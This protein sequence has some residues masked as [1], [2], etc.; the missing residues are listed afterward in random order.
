[1]KTFTIALCSCFVLLLSFSC[2]NEEKISP[3]KGYATFLIYQKV[4]PGGR[5]NETPASIL[6]SIQDSNGIKQENV[7]LN[8]FSF[9]SGYLSENLEL[10][11]GNYKLTKFVVFDAANT[12]IYATPLEGSELEK[13]VSDPLPI[14]LGVDDDGIQI[15]PEVLIVS[16]DDEPQQFGYSNFSFEII[17]EIGKVKRIVL[18]DHFANSAVTTLNFVYRHGKVETIHWNFAFEAGDITKSYIEHRFYTADGNLDALGGATFSGDPWNLSYKYQKGNLHQIES[19]RGDSITTVTF[20]EYT[21]PKPTRIENLYGIYGVYKGVKYPYN[22][23]LNFD[24]TGNLISQKNTGIPDFPEVTE[25][26]KTNY[27]NELNPLRNLIETPL[28]QALEYFDDLAFYFSTNLPSSFD[29]N[30]PYVDPLHNRITFEYEKDNQSN[31]IRISAFGVNPPT[32]RY[33][34]DIT[35]Y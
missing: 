4:R 10:P 2:Q 18:H 23:S 5:G 34:L 32:L 6:I 16:K 27:S 8:I 26:R 13:Y 9:G 7:K 31:V 17:S 14:E 35:Y 24:L 33:T 21:G 1:M 25:E 22:T 28:P 20:K 30:Y 11:F 12:S 19:N 3:H 29:A 15:T